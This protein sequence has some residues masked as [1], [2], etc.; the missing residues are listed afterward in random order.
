MRPGQ[1]MRS[2]A[3]GRCDCDD[4]LDLKNERMSE[5]CICTVL[6]ACVGEAMQLL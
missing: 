6:V 2:D 5:H 3:G 1:Y 4:T